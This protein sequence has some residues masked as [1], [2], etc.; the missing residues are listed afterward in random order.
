MAEIKEISQYQ[1]YVFSSRDGDAKAVIILYGP[2]EGG[3][4]TLIGYV[5]LTG[6][7]EPLNEARQLPTGEYLLFYRYA[8]LDDLVDMLRNEKPIYLIWVPEG[9]NNSRIS[10]LA[11]AVGEGELP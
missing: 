11:E 5:H 6:G 4:T 10:T 1:Y 8:D 3:A 9:Q 7:A 2:A